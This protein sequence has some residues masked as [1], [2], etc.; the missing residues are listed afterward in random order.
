MITDTDY[1]ARS[2][3]IKST[4]ELQLNAA[5]VVEF[6]PEKAGTISFACGINMQRGRII[7]K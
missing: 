3:D 1:L 7:V 4:S 5:V 6:T 2:T